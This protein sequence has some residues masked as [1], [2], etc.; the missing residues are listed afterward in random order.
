MK[1]SRQQHQ[2]LLKTP[3]VS[4]TLANLLPESI[5]HTWIYNGFAEYGHRMTLSE[6][7]QSDAGRI[8]KIS[9]QVDDI[10]G[11]E[12][13]K[14]YSIEISYTIS[15]K[16]MV[17]THTGEMLMDTA[18]ERIILIQLPLQQNNTWE[19]TVINKNGKDVTLKCTITEAFYEEG[20]ESYTVLYEDVNSSYYEKREIQKG[21][22]VISY[23]K[24]YIP[25]AGDAFVMGYQLFVE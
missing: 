1:Y 19:Q 16:M 4:K 7:T 11:G 13:N 6:I 15:D 17:Q 8:Y 14:D 5:G 25:D 18:Y 24:L 9:G 3:E 10:S 22:G 21:L 2:Q 23:E 20:Q 12:S